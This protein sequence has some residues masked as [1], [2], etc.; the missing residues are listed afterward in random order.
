MKKL[1]RTLEVQQHG[2]L[3]NK[4]IKKIKNGDFEVVYENVSASYSIPVRYMYVK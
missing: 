3:M 4:T 2:K 1:K